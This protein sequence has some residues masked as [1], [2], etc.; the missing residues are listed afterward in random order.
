MRKYKQNGY[1]ISGN[2]TKQ[3]IHLYMY[4]VCA[5]YSCIV[6]HLKLSVCHCLHPNTRHTR[7]S[8][9]NERMWR[10]VHKEEG[11]I[12]TIRTAKW[13]ER[14]KETSNHFFLLTLTYTQYIRLQRKTHIRRYEASWVNFNIE[15]LSE[16]KASRSVS[17]A[18][19]FIY[20]RRKNLFSFRTKLI[21]FQINFKSKL[22]V[23]SKFYQD[24]ILV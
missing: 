6:Q 3:H 7:S 9:R 24:K 22:K 16:T 13:T 2:N 21:F 11:T 23:K 1:S 20:K 10:C 18:V 4:R 15:I 17:S 14:K 12:E 19:Y 8:K 5:G